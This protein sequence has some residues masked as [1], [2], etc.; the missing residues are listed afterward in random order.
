MSLLSVQPVMMKRITP[1]RKEGKKINGKEK[2]KI[3]FHLS[4][5]GLFIFRCM[6]QPLPSDHNQSAFCV[7]LAAFLPDGAP[8]LPQLDFCREVTSSSFSPTPFAV[9]LICVG[10]PPIVGFQEHVL[11][12]QLTFLVPDKC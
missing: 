5:E 1:V 4:C 6:S 7:G 2:R 9:N 3:K 10:R 8:T 11:L 12:S